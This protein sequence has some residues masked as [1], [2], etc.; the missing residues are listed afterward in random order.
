MAVTAVTETNNL[1]IPRGTTLILSDGDA[2]NGYTYQLRIRGGTLTITNGGHE[3]VRAMDEDGDYIGPARKGAQAGVSTMAATIKLF[4]TGGDAA[5]LA[6]IDWL[7][8]NTNTPVTNL[9]TTEAAGGDFT[10]LDCTFAMPDLGSNKGASYKLNDCIPQPGVSVANADDGIEI[11]FTIES[12][13]A[14]VT[15]TQN[16]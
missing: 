13:D 15:I 14:R 5:T 6:A 3:I 10:A 16:P 9:T 1:Q 4:R 12:P 2:V 8:Q 11:S 7:V